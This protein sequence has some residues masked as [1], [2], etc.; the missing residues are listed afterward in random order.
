M[1]YAGDHHVYIHNKIFV[2]TYTCVQA[3]TDNSSLYHA[4]TEPCAFAHKGYS[5]TIPDKVQTYWLAFEVYA[6]LENVKW[7]GP[8]QNDG[9]KCWHFH[10]SVDD[11]N[12]DEC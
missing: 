8:F 12:I 11:W 9:D 1:C 6:S 2:G 4:I 5:L 7:R 3:T 10:G